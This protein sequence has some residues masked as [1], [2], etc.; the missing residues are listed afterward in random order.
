MKRTRT[1]VAARFFLACVPG[2]WRIGVSFCL[3]SF[4][5][6]VSVFALD[7]ILF[8]QDT[9]CLS[10]D[11][12]SLR[13]TS[14]RFGQDTV[15]SS[16]NAILCSQASPFEGKDST[17]E[18]A[19]LPQKATFGNQNASFGILPQAR[20]FASS[21]VYSMTA[22]GVPLIVSG[23]VFKA[24]DLHI[25]RL[26]NDFMPG[27][28]TCVDEYTQYAPALVMLGLK[29][30]GVDS[31]S[32]WSRMIV[33][34]AFSTAIMCGAVL[35]VKETCPRWRPDGSERNST[36]SGHT[37]KAFMTATMLAKEYGEDYPWLAV[38][39]YVVATGTGLLRVANDKHWMSDILMGAGIGVL[40]TELGYYLA[41]LIYK[42]KGIRSQSGW[43]W[44]ERY[45]RPSFVS[46][47]I[48]CQIPLGHSEFKSGLASHRVSAGAV[49][50][51]EGAY[52]WSPYVGIGGRFTIGNVRVECEPYRMVKGS[53]GPYFSYPLSAYW[54]V[55]GKVSVGYMHYDRTMMFE[56][57]VPSQDCFGCGAGINLTF[58][59]KERVGFRAFA[60]YDYYSAS[61]FSTN[62]ANMLSVGGSCVLGL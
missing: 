15:C 57:E 35:G 37:A 18:C 46:T 36:P 22:V 51:V 34:D 49:S 14:I 60:D 21:K 62:H 7:S 56:T 50:G 2:G 11:F 28:S 4:L 9:A 58:M 31:R 10:S 53:A 47:Y 40:S 39:G 32:S 33:S 30:C 25:S 42:D 12:E 13:Y 3:L 16:Q 6:S 23:L 43:T 59:A 1:S 5:S 54:Q 20:R 38:G 41:D 24:E 48:G 27:F 61:C 19:F 44:R 52:F 26:R 17:R 8:D 55:G 45:F 29:A